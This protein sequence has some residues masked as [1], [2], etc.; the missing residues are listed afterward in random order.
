MPDIAI[1]VP[2][3]EVKNIM[4]GNVELLLKVLVE[5]IDADNGFGFSEGLSK[6]QLRQSTGL[7]LGEIKKIIKDLYEEGCVELTRQ[8]GKSTFDFMKASILAGGVKKYAMLLAVGEAENQREEI[9]KQLL[10]PTIVSSSYSQF[11]NGHLRDAVLNAITAVFDSVRK[12]TGSPYDGKAL[13]RD[14]FY[15]DNAKLMVGDL[16][17]ESGV[18]IQIGFANILQG[19]YQSIRNPLAHTTQPDLDENEAKQ[20]LIFASLL[21]RYIEESKKAK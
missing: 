3:S 20:C 7:P 4:N 2:E 15:V 6:E 9:F 8:S 13:V 12:K 14:V 11:R 21:A 18:S 17:T 16:S 19:A 5:S 1:P 10:H